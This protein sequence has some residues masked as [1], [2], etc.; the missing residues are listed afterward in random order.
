MKKLKKRTGRQRRNDEKMRKKRS[1]REGKYT[2]S[3]K[4]DD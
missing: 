2:I 1:L 4:Y 3:E